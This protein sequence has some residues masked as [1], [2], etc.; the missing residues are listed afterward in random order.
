M[1]AFL[2]LLPTAAQSQSGPT[3]SERNLFAALEA[4]IPELIRMTGTPGLNLAIARRGQVLWE[5]AFGFADLE[6]R[7]P[8]TPRTLTHSGSMGKTYTAIAVMQLV[9]RG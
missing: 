4:D 1:A 6:R 9:E 2:A 3:P 8:M 7:I 5:G